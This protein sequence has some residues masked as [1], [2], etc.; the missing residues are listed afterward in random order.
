VIVV[1]YSTRPT[2]ILL[3]KMLKNLQ[4]EKMTMTQKLTQKMAAM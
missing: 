2:K 1:M 4:V 3:T